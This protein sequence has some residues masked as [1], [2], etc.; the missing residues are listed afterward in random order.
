[1][2]HFDWTINVSAVL[3]TIALVGVIVNYGSKAVRFLQEMAFR[4]D[5]MWSQFKRDHPDVAVILDPADWK[6]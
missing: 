2:F 4:V 1:M 3:S 5:V 6:R